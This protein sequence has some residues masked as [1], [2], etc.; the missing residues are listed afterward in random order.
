L[1]VSANEMGREKYLAP[2]FFPN[3]FIAVTAYCFAS[4]TTDL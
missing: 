2:F 1:G 4:L 3:A